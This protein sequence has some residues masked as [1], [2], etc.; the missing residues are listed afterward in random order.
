MSTN[1]KAPASPN[2]M[3]SVNVDEQAG[4]STDEARESVEDPFDGRPCN[5][6][7]TRGKRSD[8][9]GGKKKGESIG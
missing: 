1:A 7:E 9:M 5:L 6:G 4:E 2:K 3:A 8:D